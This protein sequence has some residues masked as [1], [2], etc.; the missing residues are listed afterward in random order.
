MLVS[1][2]WSGEGYRIRERG[3]RGEDEV[4]YSGRQS[5]VHVLDAFPLGHDTVLIPLQTRPTLL[6]PLRPMDAYIG[7]PR[8]LAAAAWKLHVLFI[9]LHSSGSDTRQ[10]YTI[11]LPSL[12]AVIRETND[13]N[14]ATSRSHSPFPSAL[15]F[16]GHRPLRS[17]MAPDDAAV[18]RGVLD[19][20]RCNSQHCHA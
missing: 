6:G 4:Y 13:V 9:A 20:L 1:K 5:F 14:A 10:M 15:L 2:Q 11:R 18:R 17:S 12:N 19:V 8:A 16:S 3:G 7:T